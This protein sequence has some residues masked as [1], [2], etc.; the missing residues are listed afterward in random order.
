M[1][2]WNAASLAAAS[3][4]P[5]NFSTQMGTKTVVTASLARSLAIRSA[6]LPRTHP[7]Q[8]KP[9]IMIPTAPMTRPQTAG[10][11][12]GGTFMPHLLQGLRALRSTLLVK[13]C[14]MISYDINEYQM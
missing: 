13:S 2:R 9:R 14:D 1:M 6:V 12:H 5:M 3:S 10:L 8:A 4:C 11:H 7:H